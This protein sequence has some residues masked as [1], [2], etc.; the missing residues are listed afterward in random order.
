M[1]KRVVVI[2]FGVLLTIACFAQGA[3]WKTEHHDFFLVAPDAAEV[4]YA[5]WPNGT[6]HLT[7]TVEEPY[8]A[9]DVLAY[10]G[11]EVQ[12]KHWKP[13]Y[14]RSDW[15]E[16]RDGSLR[17]TAFWVNE[18]HDGVAYELQYT[19]S[20]QEHH[21]R[22]LHVYASYGAAN[23]KPLPPPYNHRRW[24]DLFEIIQSTGISVLT[25]WDV[26]IPLV[27]L[28]VSTTLVGGALLLW[29]WVS[30]F[31][32]WKGTHRGPLYAFTASALLNVT[33]SIPTIDSSWN[34]VIWRVASLSMVCT[35][36]ILLIITMVLTWRTP[37]A[38]RIGSMVLFVITLAPFLYLAY[39]VCDIYSIFWWVHN[40]GG[41]YLLIAPGLWLIPLL[42]LA[43]LVLVCVKRLGTR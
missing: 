7:Y 16:F 42:L 18:K 17:L 9:K 11:E 3:P 2:A 8:P 6:D 10:I 39:A 20:K 37:G 33:P 13:L 27:L 41:W 38:V 43:L 24:G 40:Y 31:S 15:T 28:G 14:S 35:S 25:S 12:R 29:A 36:F 22:T 4:K 26:G 34:Q 23:L 32:D 1:K 30:A 21:L 5:Q 19:A